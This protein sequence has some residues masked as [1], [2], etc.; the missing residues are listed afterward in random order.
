MKDIL[1][2]GEFR[3]KKLNS[4]KKPF[5]FGISIKIDKKYKNTTVLYNEIFKMGLDLSTQYLAI[6]SRD[7]SFPEIAYNYIKYL[8]KLSD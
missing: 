7:I 8:K 6:F 5:D 2:S 4:S 1:N 3:K